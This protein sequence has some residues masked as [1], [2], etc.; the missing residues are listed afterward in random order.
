MTAARIRL[1]DDRGNVEQSF[2]AVMRSKQYVLETNNRRC[3]HTDAAQ[4]AWNEEG[5]SVESEFIR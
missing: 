4:T 1:R 5:Y 3:K 2:Q